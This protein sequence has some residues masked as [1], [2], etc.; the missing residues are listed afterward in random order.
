MER[1]NG[2]YV[3]F[4]DFQVAGTSPQ[5]CCLFNLEEST[6]SRREPTPS[7]K[8]GSPRTPPPPP[9]ARPAALMDSDGDA[10]GAGVVAPAA[11]AAPAAASAPAPRTHV[12]RPLVVDTHGALSVNSLQT[13]SP[14]AARC[15][16]HPSTTPPARV[17]RDWGFPLWSI[18]QAER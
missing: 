13:L 9:A 1:G 11:A 17:P 4:L 14:A 15:C 3:H 8:N 7:K 12:L 2:R 18:R 16:R 6:A 5:Y 10:D